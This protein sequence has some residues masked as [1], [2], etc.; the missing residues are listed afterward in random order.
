MFW[1]SI[2]LVSGNK[3]TVRTQAV[4]ISS[5]HINLIKSQMDN[6]DGHQDR[7]LENKEL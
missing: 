6:R 7:I 3:M 5:Y 4:Y 1:T 2:K